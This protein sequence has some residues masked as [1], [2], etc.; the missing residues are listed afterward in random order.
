[1]NFFKKTLGWMFLLLAV[2]TFVFC[3]L[4][5]PY[6]AVYSIKQALT[7]RNQEVI[8]S[9]IDFDNLRTNLKNQLTNQVEMQFAEKQQ[10]PINQVIQAF[11][12]EAIDNL[13]DQ[14]V[15]PEGIIDLF[16]S[17][18]KLQTIKKEFEPKEESTENA[19]QTN[20]QKKFPS[21]V[22]WSLNY[23]DN[24]NQFFAIIKPNQKEND[25]IEISLVREG[26]FG[27]KVNNILL[28]FKFN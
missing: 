17:A 28:P 12:Y 11:S 7:D 23:G 1:M 27:W 10:K 20:T 6:W 4:G 26:F 14:Y 8:D 16:S 3:Y 18:N 24:T 9:Y 15:T 13:V 2:G 22:T 19:N 21:N 25:K 5:S